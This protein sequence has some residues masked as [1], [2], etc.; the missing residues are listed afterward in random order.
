MKTFELLSIHEPLLRKLFE[1]GIN[2]EDYKYAP[3]YREFLA[4]Q[5]AGDKVTY[6]VMIL[7][8]KY[9]VSERTVYK[10]LDKFKREL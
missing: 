9:A 2:A 8:E 4:M 10:I 5:E 3:L 1:S 7:S 6:A